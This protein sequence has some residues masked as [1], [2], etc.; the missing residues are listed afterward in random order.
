MGENNMRLKR[1]CLLLASFLLLCACNL[2]QSSQAVS[3]P[4]TSLDSSPIV[5]APQS[6][7]VT[8][9]VSVVTPEP[10]VIYE[11]FD[12]SPAPDHFTVVRVGKTKEK[13][14][15]IIKVEAKKAFDLGRQPYVEFYADW[16]PPCNAIRENLSD[17]RMIDAFSGTYIIK[18]DLDFWESKLSG[19][20]IY[21]SGIP[22]FYEIDSDGNPT[23]RM[24]T[25][26]AWGED[27]PENIAPPMKEFFNGGNSE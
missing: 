27:V 13:L 16:C 2:V 19:T 5:T 11:L 4:K 6:V 22:A 18:V 25:G 8:P 26:A 9:T 7:E 10:Q 17:E 21:V 15:D 12:E 24:I 23:G 14:L 3:T 20:G 1:L